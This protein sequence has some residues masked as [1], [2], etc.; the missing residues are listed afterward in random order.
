M[1][2]RVTVWLPNSAATYGYFPE[3]LKAKNHA[4]IYAVSLF[5][6]FG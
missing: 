4:L 5:G 1:N 2:A 3:P 6:F